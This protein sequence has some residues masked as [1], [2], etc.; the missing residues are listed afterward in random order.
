MFANDSTRIY[1]VVNTGPMLCA[2]PVVAVI[3]IVYAVVV[4]GPHALIGML[5][6]IMFYP[7]QY[8]LSRLMSK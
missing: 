8:V 4:L 3:A 1:E 6:F 7:A 2:A 5:I